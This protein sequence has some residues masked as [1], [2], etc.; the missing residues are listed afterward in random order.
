MSYSAQACSLHLASISSGSF[1][2]HFLKAYLDPLTSYA[3]FLRAFCSQSVV[4]SDVF[5]MSSLHRAPNCAALS[6]RLKTHRSNWPLQRKM[7]VFSGAVCC[8]SLGLSPCQCK[9]SQRGILSGILQGARRGHVCQL[10]RV[11]HFGGIP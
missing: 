10:S 11:S 5:S 9:P 3:H 2:G 8:I 4:F 6:P 1:D 7:S